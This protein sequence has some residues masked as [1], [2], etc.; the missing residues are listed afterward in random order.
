MHMEA[1]HA[2]PLEHNWYVACILMGV[3]RVKGCNSVQ[4][5]PITLEDHSI[6]RLV[7]HL[8]MTIPFDKAFWAACLVA[9]YLFFKKFNLLLQNLG[10]FDPSDQKGLA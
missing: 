9:F 2:N 6:K 8:N 5:L 7:C 1:G 4:K 3:K 10:T